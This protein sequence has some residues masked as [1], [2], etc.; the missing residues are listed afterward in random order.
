ME[1]VGLAAVAGGLVYKVWTW[2]QRGKEFDEGG[3]LSFPAEA[4]LE[5][6]SESSAEADHLIVGQVEGSLEL[7]QVGG[8]QLGN[9]SEALQTNSSRTRTFKSF[10]CCGGTL[11]VHFDK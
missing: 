4:G 9:L 11:S 5:I 7:S 8:V 3:S 10:A 2:A 6:G 1:W